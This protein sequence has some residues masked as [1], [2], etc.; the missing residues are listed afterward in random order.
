MKQVK[1]KDITLPS[2]SELLTGALEMSPRTQSSIAAEIG[3]EKPNIITM[4]KQGKTP[5]PLRVVGPMARAIGLDPVYLMRVV[6]NEQHPGLMDVLEE[7]IGQSILSRNEKLMVELIR[8][9][10]SGDDIA[11]RTKQ[12]KD[13]F[14]Q[15]IKKQA[16]TWVG[17]G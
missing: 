14:R 7:A 10:L 3:Y 4:F 13:A 2:V 5:V 15:S 8:E 11:P 9:G 12:Q 17:K 6:I 1:D 16:A